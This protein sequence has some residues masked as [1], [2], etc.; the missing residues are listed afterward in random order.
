MQQTIAVT[1]LPSGP[2]LLSLIEATAVQGQVLHLLNEREL[3]NTLRRH[4]MGQTVFGQKS[5]DYLISC[6]AVD[7]L[8]RAVKRLKRPADP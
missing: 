7:G 2:S 6:E 1:N 8:A 3:R 4:E 5:F